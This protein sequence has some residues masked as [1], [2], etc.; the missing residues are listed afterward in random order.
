MNGSGVYLG[1]PDAGRTAYTYKSMR[2]R[3]TKHSVTIRVKA[4]WGKEGGKSGYIAIDKT[5][6]GELG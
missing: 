5:N 1:T 6:R 2:K 4:V 3:A